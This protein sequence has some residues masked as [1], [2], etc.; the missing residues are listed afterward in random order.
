MKFDFSGYATKNDLQCSDGR[1]IRHGAFSGM[2]GKTVPLVW[3]HTYNE[4]SNVLGHAL[5]ETRDD[6]TYAYCTFNGTSAGT[7]AKMLVQHGDV[8]AL[9]I[10]ANQLVQKGADVVHGVIR[11]VSLVLAGANPGACIDNVYFQHADGSDSTSEAVIYTGLEGLEHGQINPDSADND[12]DEEDEEVL[13]DKDPLE[14]VITDEDPL[15]T[16]EDP[17]TEKI[18][19]NDSEA[20]EESS[21]TVDRTAAVSAN[22]SKPADLEHADKDEQGIK[23]ADV[24]ASMT[25]AQQRVL[26]Y[27]LEKAMTTADNEPSNAPVKHSQ[28]EDTMPRNLFEG[29]NESTAPAATLTHDQ[30]SAILE[31]AKRSGSLKAEMLQHAA[32]YGVENIDVLFPDA[33]TINTQPELVARRSEWVADVISGATKSPFPRIKSVVADITADEARAKGYVKGN[34][35]VEEVFKLLKR[36][37]SPTTIYKKQKLDRDDMIDIT[38]MDFISFLKGEM[39]L[40]LDEEIARAALV[41]DGREISSPDKIDE[42][43]IIP[44]YKDDDLYAHRLTLTASSDPAADVDAT[45]DSAIRARS[46]YRGTGTPTLF[47]TTEFVADMLLSRDKMGRR[48][49]DTVETLASALRVSKIVEVPV[50]EGVSRTTE[51]G[52]ASLLAIIVNMKDYTF[53]ASRGGE[54]TMFDDFDIDFN[55]QKYLIET[56]MSGM[57]TKPKSAIVIERRLAGA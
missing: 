33:K 24:I 53:G 2:D 37:V 3:Q 20:Q 13:E 38:D 27:L 21:E 22:I 14:D 54:V 57:L 35:K 5:L 17:D 12:E 9:S 50:F 36:T 29:S 56:R 32:S 25:E 23:V 19:A 48:H 34:R 1:V 18:P 40:M 10:F 52:T 51:N 43:K 15:D 8:T 11:E 16:S 47:A 41:G 28:E 55:Q 30:F 39:R 42:T 6:G 46:V 31:S 44:I 26:Y 45:I 7:D 49:Y 4:P